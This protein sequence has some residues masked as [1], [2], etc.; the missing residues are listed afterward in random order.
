M[1]AE[2]GVLGRSVVAGFVVQGNVSKLTSGGVAVDA[3]RYRGATI[4]LYSCLGFGFFFQAEDGIRDYKVTGVQTCALPISDVPPDAICE[5]GTFVAI[6]SGAPFA[7]LTVTNTDVAAALCGIDVNVR[8]QLLWLPGLAMFTPQAVG[9]DPGPEMSP[10]TM[11]YSTAASTTVIATIKIVAMTGATACS[12]F[13][14]MLLSS[15]FFLLHVSC[16]LHVYRSALT[17]TVGTIQPCEH[18]DEL[19]PTP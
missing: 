17:R 18:V 10:E 12:S 8:V 19:R 3:P 11:T 6:A 1:L 9:V 14:M 16:S 13:R 2:T 5:N 4:V 15:L 7:S